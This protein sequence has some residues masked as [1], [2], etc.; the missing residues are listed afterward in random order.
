MP[1]GSIIP[2]A[3]P[4]DFQQS[5]CR[6]PAAALGSLA[7]DRRTSTMLTPVHGRASLHAR[8]TGWYVYVPTTRRYATP[9]ISTASVLFPH[10]AAATPVAPPPSQ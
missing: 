8:C 6:K 7:G 9:V 4:Y 1:I 10:R 3:S 5:G 2:I